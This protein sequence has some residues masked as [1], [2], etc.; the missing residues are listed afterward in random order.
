MTIRLFDSKQVATY[1]E[2][3]KK[4]EEESREYWKNPPK[5]DPNKPSRMPEPPKPPEAM[6]DSR[7][8]KQEPGGTTGIQLAWT[9]EAFRSDVP[10]VGRDLRPADPIDMDGTSQQAVAGYAVQNVDPFKVKE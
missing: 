1:S 3:R 9:A 6:V 4:Y 5:F 7:D 10:V 2:E 8:K